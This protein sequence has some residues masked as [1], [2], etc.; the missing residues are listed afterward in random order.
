[1]EIVAGTVS[2]A[3]WGDLL[4]AW[5]VCK[6]VS[7]NAIVI[8]KDLQ[9]IGIGAGQ[10]SRV[11][12]VRIA[13]EKAREHGHDLHGAILASDAFFP[14]AD[15][16]AARP[17]RRDL[18]D[19]PAGRLA[20]RRGGG[21][22]RRGGRCRDGL[23]RAQALPALALLVSRHTPRLTRSGRPPLTN[24]LEEVPPWKRRPSP[25]G[26][27]STIYA[28]TR[29]ACPASCSSRSPT[30]RRRLRSRTRST[31]RSRTPGAALPLSVRTCPRGVPAR[32]QLDR[33][34]RERAA[35]GRRALHVRGAHARP[36]RRLDGRLAL[37]A[38]RAARRAVSLPRM[39]LGDARGDGERGRLELLR[40]V[41]DL[42]AR[43]GGDRLPAHLPRRAHLGRAPA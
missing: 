34:A 4:F 9:T 35:V 18:G 41:V 38:F 6:H 7:S 39:R 16:P 25:R 20:P 29:S 27:T 26:A 12:A 15:G 40:P 42:G 43:D 13:V 5:R 11:D 1:M 30:W 3:Q 36:V 8:A 2:E 31:S 32:R 10:M 21:R 14:F 28:S 24:H 19:R 22:G 17:R 33:P 23:H 37:P